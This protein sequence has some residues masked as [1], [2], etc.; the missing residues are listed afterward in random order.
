VLDAC[1]I[2]GRLTVAEGVETAAQLRLLRTMGCDAIQGALTA[3]PAPVELLRPALLA[4]R[5]ELSHA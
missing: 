5:I 1:R 3:M 2:H 4:G